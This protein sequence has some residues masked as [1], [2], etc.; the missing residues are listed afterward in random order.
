[1]SFIQIT[2]NK[3]GNSNANIQFSS[4]GVNVTGNMNVSSFSIGTQS[5]ANVATSGSYTDLSNKPTLASVA[6]SGSYTDLSNRPTL[7]SVATSGSYTDL[8][9]KPTI[10]QL[11]TLASVATSG[12]YKDLSN[13]PLNCFNV[14]SPFCDINIPS[15]NISKY[16]NLLTKS[17][18][19][20]PQ[21]NGKLNNIS[22]YCSNSSPS[23]TNEYYLNAGRITLTVYHSTTQLGTPVTIVPPASSYPNYWQYNSFNFSNQSIILSANISY[24]FILTSLSDTAAQG[25]LPM[26]IDNTL[27]YQVYINPQIYLQNLSIDN[28]LTINGGAT[29][30]GGA[31][32]DKLTLSS[33]PVLTS[34]SSVFS[35]LPTSNFVFGSTSS[36]QIPSTQNISFITDANTSSPW[37]NGT[38]NGHNPLPSAGNPGLLIDL[39]TSASVGIKTI[40]LNAQNPNYT[41]TTTTPNIYYGDVV[42]FVI[43]K[44][45]LSNGT[46]L[47]KIVLP[48]AF[49]SN[50]GVC[51]FSL[52]VITSSNNTTPSNFKMSNVYCLNPNIYTGNTVGGPDNYLIMSVLVLTDESNGNLIYFPS[53]A[54]YGNFYSS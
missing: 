18:V 3:I 28:A 19:F 29:I 5:L 14:E 22:V 54:N 12:S 49:N 25:W 48:P 21:T 35:N 38:F 11:P 46:Y 20:V 1:M 30:S 4:T 50:A 2:S 10:P 40:K 41:K 36:I 33:F 9:N 47:F 24:T 26:F 43:F 39:G 17:Q 42:N 6:T 44:G 45:G 13:K 34:A 23:Y 31:T 8:S 32:M 52:G 37:Y 16:E 7:A 27:A 51:S 15:T 53:L